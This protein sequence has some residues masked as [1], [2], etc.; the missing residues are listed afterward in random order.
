MEEVPFLNMTAE[1]KQLLLR[2][3]A[4]CER[5]Q[6]RE[7]IRSSNAEPLCSWIAC[8]CNMTFKD[9]PLIYTAIKHYPVGK[10]KKRQNPLWI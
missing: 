9:I 1:V 6:R 5:S 7:R 2:A 3:T 4:G 8:R 10:L